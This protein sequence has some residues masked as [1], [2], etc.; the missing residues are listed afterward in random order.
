[1]NI[2][3]KDRNNNSIK[4]GDKVQV[5]KITDDSG[6][7]T[8][9]YGV[10]PQLNA[11]IDIVYIE[12]FEGIITYDEEKLMI[13]IK[14]ERRSLPLSNYIRYNI[15]NDAFERVSKEDLNEIVKDYDLANGKYETIIDYLVKL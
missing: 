1:M 2:K 8:D 13:V 7:A 9:L 4:L 10:E 11:W 6:N 5:L 15:W 12:S 3:I 14:G